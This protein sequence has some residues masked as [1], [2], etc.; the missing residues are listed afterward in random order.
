MTHQDLQIFRNGNPSSCDWIEEVS[1]GD[2]II[3]FSSYVTDGVELEFHYD[4]KVIKF[5]GNDARKIYRA[6]FNKEGQPVCKAPEPHALAVSKKHECILFNNKGEP[7]CG[8]T[9]ESI[10]EENT[11]ELG[12]GSYA[13]PIIPAE[14]KTTIVFRTF[15]PVNREE[16]FDQSFRIDLGESCGYFRTSF[17]YLQ[18]VDVET[19]YLTPALWEHRITF[20]QYPQRPVEK[21]KEGNVRTA[22]IGKSQLD[23]ILEEM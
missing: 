13:Y 18:A 14:P 1:S 16:L 7:I 6:D 19:I 12:L 10:V 5:I 17:L 8:G 2:F 4:D 20:V 22:N 3:H 9:V 11:Q 23:R 21:K 15:S